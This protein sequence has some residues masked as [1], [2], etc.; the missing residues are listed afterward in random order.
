MRLSLAKIWEF[1]CSARLAVGL[2]VAIALAAALGSLIPQNLS[3]EQYLQVYSLSSYALLKGLGLLAIFSSWWFNSFFIILAVNLICCSLKHFPQYRDV[4]SASPRALPSEHIIDRF[5]ISDRESSPNE[6][7]AQAITH[8]FC[9]PRKIDQGET[10]E[11]FAEKGRHGELGF[12]ITHFSILILFVGVLVGNFL[13]FK[14]FLDI[15]SGETVSRASLGAGRE[16][17]ELDF[18]VR[19]DEFRLLH[20][21]GGAKEFKSLLSVLDNGQ[22]VRQE[23]V[24]ANR[25][26]VYKGVSLYQGPY[27]QGEPS[28]HLGLYLPGQ[29]E[30]T[31]F[32]ASLLEKRTLP[33]SYISFQITRYYRDYQNRGPALRL[34]ILEPGRPAVPLHLFLNEP[35][36]YFKG[37][38]RWTFVFQGV[39]ET[40][41]VRFQVSEDPGL[42]L[43]WAGFALLFLGIAAALLF[44]HRRVWVRLE[45]EEGR[46]I[47]VLA[48]TSFP[49]RAS[50]AQLLE[51]L[52]R[53]LKH[54]P[55]EPP[56]DS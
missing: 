16:P 35:G 41:S 17:K 21:Q 10:I 53:Q 56:P 43:V 49:T 12:L 7:Y 32:Q 51:R 50:F 4:F 8:L 1:L 3:P 38:N 27:R 54:M 45:Q 37:K 15:T 20:H 26:L 28:F 44:S 9:P 13:G 42:F 39:K 19:A 24:E 31:R 2:L 23:L 25:P 22:V 29:R 34:L 36:F 47:A 55:Q 52:R 46:K 30:P 40:F 18:A 33:E 14:G 48:G 5:E 6:R 11:L